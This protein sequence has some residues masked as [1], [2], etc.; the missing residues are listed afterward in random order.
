MRLVMIGNCQ[1]QALL[2]LYTRFAEQSLA[3][4]ITYVRSY[5]TISAGDRRAIEAAD[6]IVEQTQ[7]FRAKGNLAEIETS[8]ER[9]PV[10]LVNCGFLWPFAGQPH[11]DNPRPSHRDAGPYGSE[12]SDAFLNRLIKAGADPDT[13]VA[14]YLALDVNATVNLDRLLEVSLEKQRGRDRAC[15]FSIAPVIEEYF[16]AEQVFLTP[17]HPNVRVT[18]A[19]AEQF[20]ARL[21]AARADIERMRRALRIT[22]FPKEEL[23][24]HP[25]V[26]RHFGLAWA[27]PTRTYRFLDEGGFTFTQFARRYAACEWN[28]ALDAG[29]AL[30][31]GSDPAAALPLLRQGLERSPD[32]AFGHHALA[33]ALERLE[34]VPEAL[35]HAERAVAL[36]PEEA[37]F[38]LQYGLLL[39][40]LGEAARGERELRLAAALEPFWPHYPAMLAS[41]LTRDGAPEE[42]RAVAWQGLAHAPYA[43]QLHMELGHALARL[44][45]LDA[46][47]A[48]FGRAGELDP[49]NPAPL[50]ELARLEEQRGELARAAALL[51]QALALRPG[52]GAAR[53]RLAGL[54]QR[55]DP[56]LAEPHWRDL[57]AAPPATADAATQ[58]MHALRQA[59]RLDDAEAAGR[60]A[61]RAFP[62]A[63]PPRLALASVLEQRGE[64]ELAWLE[65]ENALRAAPGDVEALARGGYLLTRLGRLEEAEQALRGAIGHG[66]R[67]AHILGELA[68]VLGLLRRHDE[69]VA[70]REQASTLDPGNPYRVFQLGHALMA[71]GRV[72]EAESAFGLAIARAPGIGVFHIDLSHTLARAG[73][74]AEAIAAARRG[75]ALDPGQARFHVHHGHLLE[76]A[77]RWDEAEAAYRAA[78]ALAPSD[79]HAQGLLA[80]LRGR[81][82]RLAETA[83][84]MTG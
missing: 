61:V 48:A 24:V 72:E 15:G 34:R 71:A 41:R 9:I 19:L 64:L 56:T 83:P 29:I 81:R 60:E 78:L 52:D 69:A 21:G 84:A 50:L 55:L 66:R 30:A 26:A 13:A 58:L 79:S 68:H 37:A 4:A 42:A 1:I 59:G 57:L 53:L 39:S 49:A 35:A 31:R 10:P 62:A 44:G 82:E 8:A 67:D 25:A 80:R 27:T 40:R 16:R 74:P 54:L 7:D 75:V 12:S 2:G 20:L 73:R 63:T 3:R 5:D 46:A 11:P 65:I 47:R 32:T 70:L 14:K 38:R 22:P 6:I 18:I 43:P 51:R 28:E 45:E 23:P 76:Q 17:Y 77:G 33:G 36:R